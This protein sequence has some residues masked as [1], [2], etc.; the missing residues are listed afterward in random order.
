VSRE[1]Q[2]VLG[3]DRGAAPLVDRSQP[4]DDHF[5]LVVIG[6]GIAGVHIAREAAV[7]GHSVLVLDKGDF[8]SGTS[9]G[10]TKYLH[11]GIRYLEQRD[12][13]VV[14][15]SL[16]ERRI[17][18]LAAP[19]LV[20]PMPFLLPVWR[21]SKPGRLLIGAGALVYSALA[22]D[23]NRDTPPDLRIGRPRW[24]GRAE[25]AKQVPW[26]ETADLLGAIVVHDV[27]NIHPERLL[28]ALLRDAVALGAVARNH[29]E[30]TGFRRASDGTINGVVVLD[31]AAGDAMTV[32]ARRV[33][34]AA[35]PWM[36]KVLGHLDQ[37][38]GPLVSPSKGV[39]LL[40]PERGA[41]VAVMAR[42]RSGRHVIVSPWQQRNLIGPSDTPVDA[43]PDE[44]AVAPDDVEIVLGI[45]NECRSE[46]N[47]LVRT[48]VD[49]VTLGVR[50]LVR[51]PGDPGNTDTYASSRRHQVVDH[52][53]DGAAGLWSV[54]GGKWTTGRAIAEDV[55]A[56]VF[57]AR[58]VGRRSPTRSRPVAGVHRFGSPPPDILDVHDP[59][60]EDLGLSS[61]VMRHVRRCYGNDAAAVF[62]LAR[63]KPSL[64]ER[65]SERPG[66]FDIAAQVVFAVAAEGA[67]RLS[68][69]LD[70]RLVLGTLGQVPDDE[71]RRVSELA[72]GPAGW[73]DNGQA[74]YR[75][76]VARRSAIRSSWSGAVER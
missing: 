31:Q 74:E 51:N 66:C 50:P 18:A 61:D 17:M 43:G 26:I 58:D 39:H 22:F 53:A 75:A 52:A 34:N 24:L 45:V 6:A 4:L 15:E 25:V 14:R 29:A 63:S 1:A 7:R 19:H 10:T 40:T 70:R 68:D 64:A 59:T 69:V 30:V 2:A 71:I 41:A 37:P 57:G 20:E 65:V 54:I 9:S 49:D 46:H 42:G 72:A 32:T 12:V 55:M 5:D 11:G 3:R 27:Q 44:V 56:E 8:G 48:D 73:S 35:G 36:A 38:A 21:W 23:R 76:E 13:A 16:R 67:L 62:G 33:V 47:Q 28:M 60:I